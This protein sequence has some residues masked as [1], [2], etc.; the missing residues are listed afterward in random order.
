MAL[1]KL[2]RYL[3]LGVR[4]SYMQ[5]VPVVQKPMLLLKNLFKMS[6][7]LTSSPVLGHRQNVLKSLVQVIYEWEH[8]F[9][10]ECVLI[11]AWLDICISQKN[12]IFF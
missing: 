4:P 6:Q 7:I 8:L 9:P 12:R 1:Y 2:A 5:L 11:I 10:F 3:I